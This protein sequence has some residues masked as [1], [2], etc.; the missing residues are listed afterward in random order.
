MFENGDVVGAFTKTGRCAGMWYFDEK[1]GT[2]GVTAFGDNNFTETIDGFEDGEP[3]QFR[4]YRPSTVEVFD[5]SVEF[6]PAW[7]D[8]S[9]Y[10]EN[11]L[12]M[13]SEVRL[14]LLGTSESLSSKINI[15]PNPGTGIFNIEGITGVAKITILN[16]VGVPVNE[17]SIESSGVLNLSTQ[18]HGI[19]L[20][21]ISNIKE[22]VYRKLIIR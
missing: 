12:S 20:V 6:D 9:T 13:V 19:Y 21:R 8:G 17:V 16:S 18:P 2:L 11:G 7:Q 3:I 10:T 5:L 14:L 1:K 15:Y 22:M 4:L